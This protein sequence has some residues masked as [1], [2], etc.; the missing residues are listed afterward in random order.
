MIQRVYHMDLYSHLSC[1]Q[2][3]TPTTPTITTLT[4][5]HTYLWLI[6]L[7][8]FIESLCIS[9]NINHRE[10]HQW[11]LLSHMMTNTTNTS[12][13]DQSLYNSP[14]WTHSTPTIR[15]NSPNQLNPTKMMNPYL[16]TNYSSIIWT[17]SYSQISHLV[18]HMRYVLQRV[19]IR[20]LHHDRMLKNQSNSKCLRFYSLL[21]QYLLYQ[22]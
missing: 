4:S 20:H 13:W 6:V 10:Q 15:L 7:T 16:S 3:S 19:I 22:S 1:H 9:N 5:N 14:P 11:T 17:M 12:P 8:L 21:A 2:P 18:S